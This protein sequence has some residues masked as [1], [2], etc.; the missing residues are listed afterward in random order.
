MATVKGHLAE[1]HKRSAVFDVNVASE[2]EKLRK[3][4]ENLETHADSGDELKKA[5]GDAK[6][7]IGRLGQLFSG[8]AAYHRD[9]G[10]NVEKSA[11]VDDLDKLVPTQISGIVDPSRA[12]SSGRLVPRSGQPTPS[13]MPKVD[14]QFEHLVKVD[15]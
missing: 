7:S 13:D 14:M 10:Q 12:P 2:C 8:H 11:D 6:A 15:D 1:H 5:F 9:A 3:A 4:F